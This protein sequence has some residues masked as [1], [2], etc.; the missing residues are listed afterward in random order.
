MSSVYAYII[1]FPETHTT[2][3]DK[4]FFRHF[5][6]RLSNKKFGL[7]LA[8]QKQQFHWVNNIACLPISQ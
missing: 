7:A 6:H 5:I 2:K 8:A 1:D 3:E 4:F